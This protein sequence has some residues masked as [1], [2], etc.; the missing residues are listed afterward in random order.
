MIIDQRSDIVRASR[1][2]L[3]TLVAATAREKRGRGAETSV[4]VM[5]LRWR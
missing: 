4:V 5:R 3:L 2:M 1:F